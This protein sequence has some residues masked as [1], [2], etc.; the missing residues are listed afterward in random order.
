MPRPGSFG[1]RPGSFGG[2]PGS[3]GG[4]PGNFGGRPVRPGGFGVGTGSGSYHPTGN[5]PLYSAQ[6][7]VLVGPGGP[8]DKPYAGS[9]GGFG[10]GRSSK[11]DN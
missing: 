4:R 5:R 2:R 1:G 3:F 8:Y 6:N 9:T 11:T 10:Y 7:G